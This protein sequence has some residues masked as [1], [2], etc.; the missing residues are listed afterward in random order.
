M[1]DEMVHL[2]LF[3]ENRHPH[4]HAVPFLSP[5]LGSWVGIDIGMDFIAAGSRMHDD[6]MGLHLLQMFRPELKCTDVYGFRFTLF[7]MLVLDP[8]NVNGIQVGQYGTQI[9]AF[10]KLYVMQ[11]Q[12]FFD[13]LFHLEIIGSDKDKFHIPIIFHQVA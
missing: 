11:L 7:I 6:G 9:L 12:M 3:D 5:V 2:E 8:G 4:P 13:V 1:H 10:L